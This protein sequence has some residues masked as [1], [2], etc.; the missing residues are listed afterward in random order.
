MASM[1][2]FMTQRFSL[3]IIGY[4]VLQIMIRLLTTNIA[5]LD[6]SEQIM[7]SQYFSWG[8]NEQPPLYT[9]VQMVVFEFF[10][11]SIFGLTLLKNGLLCLTYLFVYKLGL[12]LMNDR[13]KASLSALSLM[14]I[15]Q[16]VW[17]AQVDQTHT[18]LLTTA[19]TVCIYYFFKIALKE[20]SLFSF[21]M[22]GL[23]SG[24]GLNAKYNFVLVL[25]ALA[26]VAWMIKEFRYKIYQKALCL[27]FGIAFLMVLPHFLWFISHLDTATERTL[28]RM[29]VGHTHNAWLN[30]AKGI[31]DLFI[32]CIAFL[33]PFW[34]IFI[35]LFRKNFTFK[36]DNNVKAFIGYMAI[37]FIF[38][39]L[40]IALSGSTH[41]KE[42]WLQPYLFLVPLFLFLHVEIMEEKNISCYLQWAIIA[43]IIVA[44][45]V[46]IR[47]FVIDMR[48]KPT[49]ASY[50]FDIL[51]HS[52]TQNIP[53]NAPLLIHAEDKYIGG[54]LKLFIPNALVITSSLPNQLYALRDTV[55]TV[56]ENERPLL[57]LKTLEEQ[58]YQ[59]SD[60]KAQILFKNSKKLTYSVQYVV[61][62]KESK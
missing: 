38:L 8:Y 16:F 44:L 54:N 17:D 19:T 37:I 39:F 47:P 41:I 25:V 33:T 49:R 1:T 43:P 58:V 48:G 62:I 60:D 61:C 6:E 56:W 29:N 50:P 53:S 20:D 26:V 31:F 10:G 12:L 13:L 45:V 35:G 23:A 9:W 52:I 34:L 51:A 11:I 46:L 18:I 24:I 22:F 36:W 5:V 15:P 55:I 7:L 28:N 30:F 2:Q 42:R 21:V 32:S 40:M 4:F 14:L 27:S 59:C 57:F 3:F